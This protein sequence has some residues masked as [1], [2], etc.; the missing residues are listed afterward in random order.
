[1][2]IY[3]G[4]I[5]CN[6]NTCYMYLNV[7]LFPLL[8]MMNTEERYDIIRRLTNSKVILPEKKKLYTTRCKFIYQTKLNFMKSKIIEFSF[9]NI[10]FKLFK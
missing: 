4:I 2:E 6:E 3:F 10:K 8:C 5:F 9:S 7:N 1:M